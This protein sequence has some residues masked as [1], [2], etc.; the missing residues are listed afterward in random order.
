MLLIPGAA[1]LVVLDSII[2]EEDLLPF[3]GYADYPLFPAL[4]FNILSLHL[5]SPSHGGFHFL[6]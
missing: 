1:D 4:D 6:M 2:L 3:C 5:N